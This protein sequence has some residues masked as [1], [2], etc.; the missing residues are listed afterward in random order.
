MSDNVLGPALV[1]PRVHC[2]SLSNHKLVSANTD[3]RRWYYVFAVL[4]PRNRRSRPTGH[5]AREMYSLSLVLDL[6]P[7]WL[8]GSGQSYSIQSYQNVFNTARQC[9]I[10]SLCGIR[11]KQRHLAN[12][13]GTATQNVQSANSTPATTYTPCPQKKFPPLNSL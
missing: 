12:P 13:T 5:V 2:C 6:I 7:H 1:N 10:N 8:H 11:V 4:C 3:M 9:Y